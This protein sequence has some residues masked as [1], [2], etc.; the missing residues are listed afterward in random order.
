MAAEL[1][2]QSTSSHGSPLPTVNERLAQ[3][4]PS[5]ELLEYYRRKI[6]EFDNEHQ[7]MAAKLEKYRCTYEEQVCW[8]VVSPLQVNFVSNCSSKTLRIGNYPL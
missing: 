1:S 3:L 8:F 7:E 4:R 5:K 6:A 2:F